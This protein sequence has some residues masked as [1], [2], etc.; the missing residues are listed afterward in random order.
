MTTFKTSATFKQNPDVVLNTAIATLTH[1]GFAITRRDAAS[2]SLSGPGLTSTKQNAILFFGGASGTGFGAP[3]ALGWTWLLAAMAISLLA[4]SPW[5]VLSPL[6][7]R[8]MRNRT[9]SA[10]ETLVRNATFTA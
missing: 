3:W 6:M 8:S 2:A 9:H 5:F 10:L 1:N 7:A 4:V